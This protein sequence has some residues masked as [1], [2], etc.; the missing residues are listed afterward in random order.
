MLTAT[1]Q[2]RM[3][4]SDKRMAVRRTCRKIP[5]IPAVLN[6]EISHSFNNDSMRALTSFCI[7]WIRSHIT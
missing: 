7:S 3:D 6:K 2:L 5:E 4:I 1:N